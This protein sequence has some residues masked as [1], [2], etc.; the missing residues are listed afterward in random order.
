MN[1]GSSK[2]NSE[3]II[4]FG[5]DKRTIPTFLPSDILYCEF[6]DVRFSD[7]RLKG[8]KFNQN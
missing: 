8:N 5:W 4:K 6:K 1:L 3:Q 7:L 2:V